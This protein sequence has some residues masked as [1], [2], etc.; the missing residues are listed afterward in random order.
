MT[1]PEETEP[2]P[3]EPEKGE[4]ILLAAVL[5]YAWNFPD[6]LC[7]GPLAAAMDTP[8]IL[9]MTGYES[10]AEEYV[11]SFGL[12]KGIILGGTGLISDASVREI[13]GLGTDVEISLK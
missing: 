9:T 11:Q 10:Q 7:G 8:L 1:E 4:V 13:F 2:E 5:A 6:G 3:T 12:T